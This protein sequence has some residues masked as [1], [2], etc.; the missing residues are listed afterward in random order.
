MTTTGN[1]FLGRRSAPP[2]TILNLVFIIPLLT[3]AVGCQRSQPPHPASA[4]PVDADGEVLIDEAAKQKAVAAKDALFTRLSGRLSEVIRQDGPAAAIEVCSREAA[5]IAT[6]VGQEHQVSIGR[7][8][9][10]LRN[11]KN[12]PPEWARSLV[13]QRTVDPHFVSLPDGGAAALLPIRLKENCLTCHGPTDSIAKGVRSKL[14]ELY[15]DDQA[16]GFKEGD[17][18][19]W[20]WVEVPAA[21]GDNDAEQGDDKEA[22]ASSNPQA[23]EAGHGP[24][25]GRGRGFG[26]GMGR[27]PG[28]MGGNREDMTT[29]HAMFDDRDK[30]NRTVKMLPNGAEAVTE[31]DDEK[32][33]ALIQKHVPAME[34]RVHENAPLPPMTFH[35]IF[36]E[37]IKHADDYTLAYEETDKGIKVTYEAD[38]PFVVMLVQEHA[39]L[40]SRFIKNG[41]EEIH[42]PYSLPKVGAEPSEECNDA[43]EGSRSTSLGLT[44]PLPSPAIAPADNPTTPALECQCHNPKV[45]PT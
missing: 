5:D 31:S 37:L 13:E 39:K 43:A 35:P 3:G 12:S 33:A 1:H 45:Q 24:G 36:V 38:D 19:G 10:Q 11:S 40:V 2:I 32:I 9:F 34:G 6:A 44:R 8:S 18:R 29:L 41:M 25:H 28:M 17:L 21:V 20:F 16:T 42:K 14:S 4:D 23:P 7:T 27:G 30:I 22:A 15:P 26:R